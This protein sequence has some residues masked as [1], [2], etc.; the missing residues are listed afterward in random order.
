L[1]IIT[2]V[3][4]ARDRIFLPDWRSLALN[5]YQRQNL[6]AA[7]FAVALVFV[8]T[9]PPLLSARFFYYLT[10]LYLGYRFA[11]IKTYW[12]KEVALCAV[13]AISAVAAIPVSA[14]IDGRSP[15]G[16]AFN[17]GLTL[18]LFPML[19][20][21]NVK[22]IFYALIPAW[23]LQAGMMV[24]QWFIQGRMDGRAEGLAFT[25]D[26]AGSAFVLLGI[27]FLL[28]QPRLRWLAVPLII[29]I[30]FSGSRWTIIVGLV[31]LIGLFASRRIPW[32]WVLVGI[33]AGLMLVGVTQWERLNIATRGGNALQQS[34]QDA[35]GRL[36]GGAP[37]LTPMLLLPQGFLPFS[38]LH[39]VPLRM[40]LETGLLSAL[41]WVAVGIL[42]LYRKPRHG[43]TWWMMLAVCLL[44]IMYYHTWIGMT[45]AF[46][47]LLVGNNT[48]SDGVANEPPTQA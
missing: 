15:F 39:D 35:T 9:D 30:P 3:I 33:V 17:A 7:S 27:L 34:G 19:F 21:Q 29:V 47:W 23:F 4:R 32:R 6:S 48:L 37:I 43:Y 46:W 40:A 38:P 10:F 20:V 28:N 22:R 16:S 26:N 41:A 11:P 18:L 36:A 13:I 45:G 8:L 5:L 44:S 2:S 25:N 1:A 24:W 42:V 12:S 31:L 14:F